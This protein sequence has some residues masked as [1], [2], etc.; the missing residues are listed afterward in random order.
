MHR[1]SLLATTERQ[2]RS[3]STEAWQLP[4]P[5]LGR[6]EDATGGDG[7]SYQN[8]GGGAYLGLFR[9]PGDAKAAMGFHMCVAVIP[10]SDGGGAGAV[11]EMFHDEKLPP[12]QEPPGARHANKVCLVAHLLMRRTY[13]V[14]VS[15]ARLLASRVEASVALESL[16]VAPSFLLSL[17]P[18]PYCS[19]S[20]I[21]SMIIVP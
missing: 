4:S 21:L 18:P 17:P 16:V 12:D 11:A 3:H 9:P 6:N 14:F 10:S 15:V 7:G 19:T 13:F 20:S 1:N 2:G 5:T 8:A